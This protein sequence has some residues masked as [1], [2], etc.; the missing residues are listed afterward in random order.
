[1]ASNEVRVEDVVILSAAQMIKVSGKDS[2]DLINTFV[3]GQ[4]K[5]GR[6]ICLD[7]ELD[8][9]PL[10]SDD[11][12][13]VVDIDSIIW[14]T[15]SPHFRTPLSIYL[16]PIIE[17]KAPMHKNN[18]VYVDILVPQSQNDANTI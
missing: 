13:V 5:D 8:H 16:G 12:D 10:S 11:L 6:R 17:D 7:L 4:F 2:D 9:M 15:R 1:M 14:V 18:H 3:R